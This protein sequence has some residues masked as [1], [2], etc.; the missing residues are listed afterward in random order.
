MK[1]KYKNIAGENGSNLEL[2]CL[3]PHSDPRRKVIE[4]I[5]HASI[6]YQN[7][8]QA[9]LSSIEDNPARYEGSELWDPPAEWVRDI[10]FGIVSSLEKVD[11]RDVSIVPT[12]KTAAD[13]YHGIDFLVI[14]HDRETE[15]EVIVSV[16]LSMRQKENFKAD[17]LITETGAEPNSAYYFTE[18]FHAPERDYMDKKEETARKEKVH[19]EIGHVIA[20]IIQEKLSKEKDPHYDRVPER[21]F[22]D[23]RN[24]IEE[25]LKMQKPR[26]LA[27]KTA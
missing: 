27:R 19:F 20:D 4:R 8:A 16:D 21:V 3:Y 12:I 24:D 1:N 2:D 18:G 23:I 17:V 11:W 22:M 15:R 25:L 6:E 5:D 7:L 10:H 26:N 9:I 13:I 14:Y